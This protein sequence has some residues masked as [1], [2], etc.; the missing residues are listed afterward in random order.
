M[1]HD[2]LTESR[3]TGTRGRSPLTWLVAA[4][5]AVIIVGAGIFALVDDRGTDEPPPPP[6][7]APSPSVIQLTAPGE[8]AY[9]ARCAVPSA[10]LLAPQPTAFDGTVTSIDDDVVTLSPS[11][12]YA[13]ESADEVQVEAPPEV[14][15]QL[16]TSVEFEEGGRYLVAA[17]SDDEVVVC[18]LSD[19]YTP[20]LATLYE[21]A[22]AG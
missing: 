14:L 5:A 18:G 3:E 16:L 7:A 11:Q 1:S 2:L 6:Q 9:A 10:E 22:F 20:R 8:Q 21:Q 13:G 4:A 17:N 19:R 12:W 15:G